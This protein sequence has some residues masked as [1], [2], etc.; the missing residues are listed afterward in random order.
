[1]R[2]ANAAGAYRLLL[3]RG[4]RDKA[5]CDC[6]K[7]KRRTAPASTGKANTEFCVRKAKRA[8]ALR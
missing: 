4:Q 3:A 7:L 2:A 8:V 6:G 5:R 1:M